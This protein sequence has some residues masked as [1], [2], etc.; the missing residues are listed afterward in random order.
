MNSDCVDVNASFFGSMFLT[1]QLDLHMHA[2]DLTNQK[3]DITYKQECLEVT[4]IGEASKIF[5][6]SF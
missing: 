2:M 6:K 3:H 5:Q 1:Y 4:K